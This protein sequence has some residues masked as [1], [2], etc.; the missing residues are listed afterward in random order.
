V[1]AGAAFAQSK[2]YPAPPKDVDDEVEQHSQLWEAALDPERKPYDE[3]VHDARRLLDEHTRD[4]AR[5]ALVKLDDAVQRLPRDYRARAARGHAALILGDWTT[6]ATDL[7]LADVPDVAASTERDAIELELGICQGR[8]GHYAD[9]ERTLLHAVAVAPHGEQWM[10][11]G[12]VRIALGK[13]EEATDALTAALEARDGVE[14]TIHWLLAVAYDR[15]RKATASE[16]EA[17]KAIQFDAA[18]NLI[19]NPTYPWL[20]TGEEQYLL[21][22]AYRTPPILDRDQAR[23]ELALMYFRAFLRVAPDSPWRRRGEEHVRELQAQ[24]F[25]KSVYRTQQ[26]TSVVDPATLTPIVQKA[27]PQL[28]ACLAKLPATTFAVSIVKTGPRTPETARDRPR[29]SVPVPS[30]KVTLD[31]NLETVPQAAEDA[32]RTCLEPL[33]GKLALPPP[34]ERDTYYQVSFYVVGP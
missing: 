11:L 3:L 24:P 8:A 21:A 9:A 25:P 19:V 14:G 7:A 13:L 10:R 16:D 30:V 26:S 34:K 28:R 17:R 1:W 23:P 27:M 2:R 15:A 5:E 22:L 18:F 32:A 4:A 6:C 33:A 29:Y 20:R 12:E 31:R